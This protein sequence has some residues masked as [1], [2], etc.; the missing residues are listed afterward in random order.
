VCVDP[1]LEC[2]KERT[3]WSSCLDS[4]IERAPRDLIIVIARV[5]LLGSTNN[6]VCEIIHKQEYQEQIEMS[7][8]VSR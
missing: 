2:P 6:D 5:L 3:R 1:E 8:P 4:Q 7:R